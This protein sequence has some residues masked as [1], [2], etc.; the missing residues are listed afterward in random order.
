D[1]PQPVLVPDVCADA[2]LVSLLPV[3][4]REGVRAC[5][6]IPLTLRGRLV[7]KFMLYY[8]EPHSFSEEELLTA[9]VLGSY[10]GMA[11]DRF[12][13]HQARA[14]AEVL[15]EHRFRT[16]VEGMGVAAYTTNA[17]GLITYFNEEAAALWGRRPEIGRDAWC[18]SWQIYQPTGEPLPHDQC[19]M[20]VALKEDRPVRDVEI[21]AERPDGE[22]AA[23]LPFPTPLHDAQGRIVGAVNILIDITERKRAELERQG[24]LDAEREARAE[25]EA[26]VRARNEFLSI[27]SH[28][29]RN[30]VAGIRGAAQ[31]LQRLLNRPDVDPE[32]IKLYSSSLVDTS[33]RISRLLDDLLDVAR[34]E[35]GQLRLHM[36]EFDLLTM[37]HATIE[38][39]RDQGAPHPFEVYAEDESEPAS[40][41][42]VADAVR[43]RQVLANLVENAVKY[44]PEAGPIVVALVRGEDTVT[45]RVADRG[46]G[47]PPES[48]EAIFGPF[49]RAPNASEANIPG[50]G[51]GLHICRQLAEM[52]GGELRAESD[53]VDSGS[54]FILT[55]PVDSRLANR[56]QPP[57]SAHSQAP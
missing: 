34:L 22:R 6:F 40:W 38:E 13:A 17:D 12:R 7:G 23:V 52:H 45:V 10:I 44:S 47:F 54:R 56:Y 16:L 32:R 8:A 33:G 4:D 5:A 43:L 48:A 30:P 36:E 55:L 53:G 2:E 31:M 11:L 1:A 50:L 14:Q 41:A 15:S 49:G 57:A 26:A 29:L 20:A 35:T 42:V 51:L 27:A 3:L 39:C 46:I 37:V 18:G 19:P 28:E 24:L 9:E 25:A 21:I